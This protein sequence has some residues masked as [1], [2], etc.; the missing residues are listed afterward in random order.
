[1][2]FP[3]V[4]DFPAEGSSRDTLVS[5]QGGSLADCFYC[6]LVWDLT[7]CPH[8]DLSRHTT[9]HPRHPATRPRRVR[10]M[11]ATCPRHAR[12][13]SATCRDMSATCP[14]HV[15]DMSATGVGEFVIWSRGVCYL[16][17]VFLYILLCIPIHSDYILT[18][19]EY[20]LYSEEYTHK[21]TH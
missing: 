11:S 6:K 5:W 17:H 9:T 3:P 10:D 15:R 21:Y 1:M 4:F 7:K 19:S 14:R 8:A 16:R 18:R 13:M 2:H 12:D 20:T